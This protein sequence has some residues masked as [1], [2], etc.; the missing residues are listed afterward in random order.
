MADASVGRTTG[1]PLGQLSEIIV[2]AA[3]ATAVKTHPEGR[4]A[5]RHTSGGS[6]GRQVVGRAGSNVDVGIDEIHGWSG[7]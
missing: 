3:R 4:L 2:K 6:H 5:D 7:G 1:L